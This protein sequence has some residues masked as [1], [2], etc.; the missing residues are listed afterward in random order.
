M[1]SKGT[2]TCCSVFVHSS[3]LVLLLASER[4]DSIVFAV[5]RWRDVVQRN[6]KVSQIFKWRKCVLMTGKVA[7]WIFKVQK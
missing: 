2:K 3:N 1:C 7:C 5:C 4:I 6:D